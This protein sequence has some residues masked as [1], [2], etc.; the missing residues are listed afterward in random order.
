MIGRVWSRRRLVCSPLVAFTLATKLNRILKEQ[1][2]RNFMIVISLALWAQE[3]W[4]LTEG[5]RKRLLAC[6]LKRPLT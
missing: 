2:D 6:F 3:N 1:A 5:V 4:K